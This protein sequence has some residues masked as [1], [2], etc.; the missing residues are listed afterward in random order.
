MQ[1]E[2]F[3]SEV[4]HA[5]NLSDHDVAAAISRATVETICAHLPA[6]QV[7]ELSSQ[8]PRELTDAAEAGRTQ[9][10][11]T[12]TEISQDEFYQQ[13]AIRAEQDRDGIEPA[14]R[15]AITVFKRALSRGETVDIV[16]DAPREL[17]ALLTG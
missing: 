12:P 6:E 16:F 17:D 10:S 11:D 1:T 13:V 3:V 7:R 15:A 14:V 8:L 9:T 4:A 5:A 2:E